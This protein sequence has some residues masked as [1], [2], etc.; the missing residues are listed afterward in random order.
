MIVNCVNKEMIRYRV[1]VLKRLSPKIVGPIFT[2][3]EQV[4][5]L[6]K[7]EE[8]RKIPFF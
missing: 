3:S 5:D 6:T 2:K 4:D 7:F 8:T 1:F